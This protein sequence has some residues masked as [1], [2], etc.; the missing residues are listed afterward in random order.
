MK[1]VDLNHQTQLPGE[2]QNIKPLGDPHTS[3]ASLTFGREPLTYFIKKTEATAIP[4]VLS[5]PQFF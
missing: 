2:S 4:Q 1:C 5:R 3:P